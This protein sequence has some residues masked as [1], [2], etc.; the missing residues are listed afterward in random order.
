MKKN[1]AFELTFKI[2]EKDLASYLP[3][4]NDDHFPAVFATSRMIALMEIT[5]ARSMKPDLELGELS[6]GVGVD[7]KHI[8]ATLANETVTIIS[9]FLQ[10]KGK[11]FQFKIEAFDGGGKIGSG[12]H[13]RAIISEERLITGAK[14]RKNEN[15]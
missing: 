7:I 14:K 4:S 5:A 8:A 6:V 10:M 3:I 13:T 2:T 11:L 9:T 15:I 12:T 1:E